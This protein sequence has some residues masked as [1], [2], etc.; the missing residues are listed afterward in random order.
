MPALRLLAPAV[1]AQS[2]EPRIAGGSAA[3]I[4]QYP[5]QAALVLSPAKASG[6]AHQRQ[7]CGGSL[8]TSSIVLTAAHCLYDDDPD[9]NPI[10]AV[11]V[12]LPGHPGGDGTKRVDPDDVDVVLGVTQLS[13]AAPEDEHAVL[14]ASHHPGF[15]TS[16]FQNDI[17]YLVLAAPVAAGPAVQTIDLAGDDEVSVWAPGTLVDISGWGSTFFGGGTVDVLRA[18]SVPVVADAT[19][20]SSGVYDTDFDP[21]TM[22]CAGYPEGGVDSCSGDS[23]GPLASALEGGGYRLVGITSCGEGCGL[24]AVPGVYAR[25]AQSTALVP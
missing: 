4:E 5:W 13:R 1:S 3:S 25:I 20:G 11:G 14:D 21:A 9:C 8:I 23:G 22:V 7:F 18:A 15:D 19:C 2:P 24:S 17:G 16:T 10:G 12:C 6:D